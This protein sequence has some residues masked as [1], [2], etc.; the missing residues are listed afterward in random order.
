M[1]KNWFYII[2]FSLLM[3]SCSDIPGKLLIME[4]N[5]HF[6]RRMYSEAIV[7]YM[8]A[9]EYAESDAYGEYGLGSVYLAIGE[10]HAALDRFTAA[11]E[12]LETASPAAGKTAGRELRY[13]IHYNTGVVLFS[14]GDFSGAAEYFRNALRIDGSKIEA[15]RNLEL[16]L[17]SLAREK[18][19]AAA[20]DAAASESRAAFFDYIR[21]REINQWRTK[22]WPAEEE[23]DEPDY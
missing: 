19:T 15:K 23:S 12:L 3:G 16:S 18:L 9:L 7:P 11:L 20:E 17:K 4:G 10:D 22:E 13:R 14:E 6:S 1:I 5:S 21:Q 8:K 2:I